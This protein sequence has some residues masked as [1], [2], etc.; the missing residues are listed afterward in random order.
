MDTQSSTFFKL[1]RGLWKQIYKSQGNF[2]YS[3]GDKRIEE[4]STGWGVNNQ[5]HAMILCKIATIMSQAR[6][7]KGTHVLFLQTWQVRQKSNELV[8]N[9]IPYHQCRS[10]L[11]RNVYKYHP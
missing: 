11:K 5:Q 6:K 7:Y 10:S 8:Q 9:A 4:N 1:A 3:T 2:C